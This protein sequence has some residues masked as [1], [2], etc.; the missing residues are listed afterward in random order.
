MDEEAFRRAAEAAYAEVHPG[1]TIFRREEAVTVYVRGDQLDRLELDAL[2]TQY[3]EEGRP[4]DFLQGWKERARAELEARRIPLAE[5][6][7]VIVPVI[8]SG[9]WIRAQDYGAIGSE[10]IRRQ[11][12]PWRSEIA[13]EVF[14]VLGIPEEKLGYRYAS[15]FE[16]E[17]S[18]VS[19]EVWMKRARSNVLPLLPLVNEGPQVEAPDGSL[20]AVD[21]P[22]EPLVSSLVLL[23]PFR[24]ALVDRFGKE[25]VGVAVPIRN[26]LIAFDPDTFTARKPVRA[27]AHKLY[28]T[29]NHP[30]FRGLLR[31]YRDRFEVLEPGR[32]PKPKP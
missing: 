8:K 13:E 25:P 16:I 6:E 26:V 27:R 29:Q 31:V 32:T 15:I 9:S 20:L 3:Q 10:R 23:E 19:E 14:V 12:R 5:A 4:G 17:S 24:R 7:S 1:F 21:L 22:N 11:I 28:D 2:W 18:T 30:A